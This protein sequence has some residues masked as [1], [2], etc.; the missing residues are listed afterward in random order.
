MADAAA[1]A[2]E[3]AE[4]EA[5]AAAAAAD[6][7]ADED[8]DAV[9]ADAAAVAAAADTAA[10]LEAAAADAATAGAPPL[11]NPTEEEVAAAA[12]AE[13]G[14]PAAAAVAAIEADRVAAEA[15]AAPTFL[16]DCN[17]PSQAGVVPVTVANN[18]GCGG[19]EAPIEAMRLLPQPATTLRLF[20]STSATLSWSAHAAVGLDVR[21]YARDPL[22]NSVFPVPTTSRRVFGGTIT[23]TVTWVVSEEDNGM[24]FYA[25]T[26]PIMC[27][28][29]HIGRDILGPPPRAV[30]ESSGDTRISVSLGG[31]PSAFGDAPLCPVGSNAVVGELDG[32]PLI[33]GIVWRAA[34]CE[35]CR[36][37]CLR[38]PGCDTWVWGAPGDNPRPTDRECWL[39]KAAAA[40]GT[41][42]NR[43][44]LVGM[45]DSP[46]AAAAA[47][48]SSPYISGELNAN[49]PCSGEWGAQ[50]GGK[51]LN[52]G[53]S[54]RL[55][56]CTECATAC[57]RRPGCNV[58]AY[59]VAAMT[60]TSGVG[61][62]SPR[63]DT[64]RQCWLRQVAD[65]VAP[66]RLLGGPAWLSGV[67][68]EYD[69]YEGL[70][71]GAV[72]SRSEGAEGTS[73]LLL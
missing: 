64:Y 24:S 22:S 6:V 58:W 14:S 42:L 61:S 37:S 67:I 39:K 4:D 52:D 33:D 13:D 19:L 51:N 26:V 46:H 20:A 2:A 10:G 38:H 27:T 25:V 63:L 28:L 59:G 57:R 7:P 45:S 66:P 56:S 31:L 1:A 11:D 30:S 48:L 18:G 73:S 72:R 8:P 32:I 50:Y 47:I 17:R 35:D 12:A 3:A 62:G 69:D 55:L 23:S 60:P 54:T 5:A 21:V 9:A 15:A 65:A 44:P 49:P 53:T 40:N 41:A 36:S 43:A 71:A 34:T 29:D 68:D 16:F 70:G